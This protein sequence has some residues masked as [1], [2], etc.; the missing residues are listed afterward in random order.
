[1]PEVFFTDLIQRI[2]VL[3][4]LKK[5]NISDLGKVLFELFNGKLD[6]VESRR[7]L[8]KLVTDASKVGNDELVIPDCEIS[9]DDLLQRIK[10]KQLKPADILKDL[11]LLASGGVIVADELLEKWEFDALSQESGVKR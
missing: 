5:I 2:V 6:L 3:I 4:G 9:I 8:N 1:M 11:R 7:R 10:A